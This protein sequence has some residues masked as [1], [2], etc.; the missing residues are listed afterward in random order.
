[1]E[2]RARIERITD[3]AIRKAVEAIKSDNE[4]AMKVAL[5]ALLEVNLDIRQFM[6]KIYKNIPKKVRTY[7]RPTGKK[8]DIVTGD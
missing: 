4:D 5:V 6:R 7:K 1:M 3:D 8:E 2:E